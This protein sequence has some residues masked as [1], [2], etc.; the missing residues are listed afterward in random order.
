[1]RIDGVK[2]ELQGA[3][4]GKADGKLAL[5]AVAAAVRRGEDR[6]ELKIPQAADALER[7][8]HALLFDLK[9]RFVADVPVHTAAALRGD[10]AVRR[11][12]VGRRLKQLFKPAE[13]VLLQNLDGAHGAAVADGGARHKDGHPLRAADAAALGGHSRD[14][15]LKNIVFPD[16]VKTSGETFGLKGRE[17]QGSSTKYFWFYNRCDVSRA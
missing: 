15:G 6:L 9:L 11:D 3:V 13:G 17:T 8:A 1:M 16:H 10:G 7:V 5:V 12:A 14:F 2:A 4:L